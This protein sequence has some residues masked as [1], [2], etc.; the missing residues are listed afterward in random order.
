MLNKYKTSITITV[1]TLISFWIGSSLFT[2]FTYNTPPNISITGITANDHY[3]EVMECTL[4]ANN[5]YKISYAYI[6]LDNKPLSIPKANSIKAK[7]FELPFKIDTNNLNDG[8]HILNIEAVD[9]S[10]HANKYNKQLTFFVD[11]TPLKAA[12]L[13]P[14]YKV[15]QGNTLHLQIQLN[16]QVQSIKIKLLSKLYE[17]YP[18]SENSTLYESF[19]P[20]DCEEIPEEYLLYADIIDH[21]GNNSKLTNTIRINPVKFPKQK[22]FSVATAKLDSEK[23]VSMHNKILGEAL[24]K[25]AKDSPK[26]KLWAGNFETPT[27][28]QRISTPFGEIRITPE[29]GRYLHK[30][31]DIVNSPKSVVWSSQNGKVII[32]DRYLMSGNT[33]VIDH[34]LGVFTHY[35]HLDSFA[36]IEVGETIKKGEPI[37]RI[38]MTGYANG[39]HLHWGLTINNVS[40][41][42]IEWTKKTF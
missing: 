40:V 38:G 22:G 7:T 30:A 36:D 21:V 33:I 39:Y 17:C 37:G 5:P 31:I 11:N 24:S 15:D 4:S 14:E 1:I 16:K 6:T 25:W 2:Y 42:P 18:E 23:E 26:K 9:S 12:F 28:I 29:K 3:K 32:K 10:Y 13:Q 35:C 20:I 34:G 8:N 19:I 27:I 41:N